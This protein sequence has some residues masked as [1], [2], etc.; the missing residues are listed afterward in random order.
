MSHQHLEAD[1][2]YL[3]F[4]RETNL[5]CS[6]QVAQ[7]A[8]RVEFA[9]IGA[10][11]METGVQISPWATDSQ[12]YATR[13]ENPKPD[14]AGFY[15]VGEL[16][17]LLPLK[18]TSEQQAVLKFL[19]DTH[20][21]VSVLPEAK[22]IPGQDAVEYASKRNPRLHGVYVRKDHK[23]P[24]MLASVIARPQTTQPA[25]ALPVYRFR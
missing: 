23:G 1:G 25:S 7:T 6:P 21:L 13:V 22:A 20:G 17:S 8:Q 5:Q 9:L 2:P 16:Q 18:Y 19:S 11:N 4:F 14:Q 15:S 12:L 10:T 3:T 24:Y